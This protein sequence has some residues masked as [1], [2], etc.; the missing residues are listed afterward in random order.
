MKTEAPMTP[1]QAA[2]L[3]GFGPTRKDARR[4]IDLVEDHEK[5]SGRPIWIWTSGGHRRITESIVR[6]RLPE[7]SRQ[8]LL[9]IEQR[10]QAR[11]AE[12]DRKL[13]E[14]VDDR[15]TQHPISTRVTSLEEQHEQV[16]EIL[17]TVTK[18]IERLL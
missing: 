5:K 11:L 17:E 2:K 18:H 16:I 6:R 10:I 4:F 7:L 8:K 14:R 15:I 9:A 12:I 13:D 1:S 3:Y